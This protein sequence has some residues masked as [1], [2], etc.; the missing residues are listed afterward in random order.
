MLNNCK[1]QSGFIITGEVLL[2]ST[3]VVIGLIVGMVTLRNSVTVEV[4]DT[5][6]SFGDLNQSYEYTGGLV[7]NL[8]GITAGSMYIDNAD[9]N[10]DD[11]EEG[12]VNANDDDN[13]SFRPC[14]PFEGAFDGLLTPTAV[15]S[16][17]P[18]F[19]SPGPTPILPGVGAGGGSIFTSGSGS[20]LGGGGGIFSLS[21]SFSGTGAGVTTVSSDTPSFGG[22]GGIVDLV[23]VPPS[24]VGILTLGGGN[25]GLGLGV[26]SVSSSGANNGAGIVTIP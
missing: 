12:G 20:L 14:D 17:L 4:E 10:A 22:S 11:D 1:K 26:F 3:V 8:T 7:D 2:I 16:G 5:A 13:F 18:G 6:E 21:G 19:P 23:D 25:A 9:N 15:G 24:N